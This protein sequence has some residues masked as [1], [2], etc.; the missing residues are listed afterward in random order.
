MERLSESNIRET[1]IQRLKEKIINE[2]DEY[3]SRIKHEIKEYLTS[4]IDEPVYW[5]Y[6]VDREFVL[7]KLKSFVEDKSALQSIEMSNENTDCVIY[8]VSDEEL[9]IWL[10]ED[11]NFVNSFLHTV[12][13]ENGSWCISDYLNNKF[14]GYRFT[15][16]FE[17]C[18]YNS[19]SSDN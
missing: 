17:H 9:N 15:S 8:M 4:D 14:F 19:R 16:V 7:L 13:R 18:I 12:E 1:K 2:I 5:N 11:Y 6:L 3:S 10:Q